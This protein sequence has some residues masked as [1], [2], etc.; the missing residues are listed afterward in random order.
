MGVTGLLGEYQMAKDMHFG[1][2]SAVSARH[3]GVAKLG[4]HEFGT[5]AVGRSD[6]YVL[7]TALE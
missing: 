3:R 1:A 5:R 2:F 4:N 7:S 6:G